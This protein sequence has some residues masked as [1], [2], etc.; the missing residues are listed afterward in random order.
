MTIARLGQP[1]GLSILGRRMAKGLWRMHRADHNADHDFH[2][3]FFKIYP[4][5]RQDVVLLRKPDFHR[6]TTF[7][8]HFALSRKKS[9]PGESHK[10]VFLPNTI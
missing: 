3:T 10:A 1:W 4:V 6:S 9:H 5:R 2:E 7:L 8:L